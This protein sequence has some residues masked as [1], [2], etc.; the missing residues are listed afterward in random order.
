MQ[1]AGKEQAQ[2]LKNYQG[3]GFLTGMSL[4]DVESKLRKDAAA[5][6]FT[7][8]KQKAAAE[9][10][11]GIKVSAKAQVEKAAEQYGSETKSIE[12]A[13][14]MK[15]LVDKALQFFDNIGASLTG[16][17]NAITESK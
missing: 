14:Q 4:S 11:M 8:P 9:T 10:L 3:A 13:K 17:T 2:V 1:K 15:Q 16:V 12:D 5:G 7:D 6:G